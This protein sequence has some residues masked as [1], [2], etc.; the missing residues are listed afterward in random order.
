MDRHVGKTDD[1]LIARL[2]RER[3]RAG[4]ASVI[5]DRTG[6]FASAESARDF[7]IRTIDMNHETIE[8]V[9]RGQLPDAFLTW[10]FGHETGREA[11]EDPTGSKI[12]RLRK[13]YE[14][15]VYI[16]YNP[17]SEVGYDIRTAY[18]RNF[19]PRIGR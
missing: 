1:E 16:V 12:I 9:A 7:I 19:N 6:S 3:Y 5:T 10:R 2:K 18:P 15:G 14:V 13:T 11:I 17:N 4:I 8:R